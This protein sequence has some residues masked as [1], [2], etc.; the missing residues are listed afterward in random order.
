MK[1]KGLQ[2]KIVSITIDLTVMKAVNEKLYKYNELL[3]EDSKHVNKLN[4][5]LCH[6]NS[7]VLRVYKDID[8]I[9]EQLCAEKTSVTSNIR[10]KS[11]Q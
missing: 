3:S 1:V 9:M 7:E 5:N 6:E 10:L 4:E 2:N 11:S 8:K